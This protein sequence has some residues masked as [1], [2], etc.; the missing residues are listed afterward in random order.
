MLQ[1]G[2]KCKQWKQQKE[3]NQKNTSELSV[4]NCTFSLI[5]VSAYSQLA[6]VALC[7]ST[8]LLVNWKQQIVTVTVDNSVAELL[9]LRFKATSI[10]VI[11]YYQNK[12]LFSCPAENF[13]RSLQILFMNESTISTELFFQMKAGF[14]APLAHVTPL[15]SSCTQVA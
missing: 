9:V 8:Y 15:R 3:N 4:I 7:K 1:I 11:L 13:N 2:Y 5:D 14:L 6:K 10:N 12:R